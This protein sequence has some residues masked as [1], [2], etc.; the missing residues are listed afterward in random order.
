MYMYIIHS[1]TSENSLF[2]QITFI[3]FCFHQQKHQHN[4]QCN[5]YK[6]NIIIN[7]LELI[8]LIMQHYINHATLHIISYY[9][10]ILMKINTTDNHS[11]QI[12]IMSMLNLKKLYTI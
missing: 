1:S 7:I 3:S 2:F 8:T 5:Y 9:D 10:S 12:V 11:Y 6:V 4:L